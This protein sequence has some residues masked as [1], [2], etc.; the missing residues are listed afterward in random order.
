MDNKVVKYKRY[1]VT[2]L[3]SM[4]RHSSLLTRALQTAVNIVD[5]FYCQSCPHCFYTKLIIVGLQ[6]TLRCCSYLHS[7]RECVL[8]C[9]SCC[10]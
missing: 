3:F 4:C 7:W 2:R 6:C 1:N 10:Y 5:Y 9:C 8:C